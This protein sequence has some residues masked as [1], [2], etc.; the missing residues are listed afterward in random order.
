MLKHHDIMGRN[1]W[2][3][4]IQHLLYNF[5]FGFVWLNQTV[6]DIGTFIHNLKQRLCDCKLEN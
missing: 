4:S 3:S 5:G 1:N 2:A 6:G